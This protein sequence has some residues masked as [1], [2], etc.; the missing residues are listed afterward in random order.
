MTQARGAE[1]WRWP[2]LDE[3]DGPSA[4]FRATTFGEADSSAA[5]DPDSAE[6]IIDEGRERAE[7]LVARARDEAEQIRHDAREEAWAEAFAD[8]KARLDATLKESVAEQT[9]AFEQARTA[10][11]ERIDASLEERLDQ[12]EQQLAGLVAAMAEKVI[13][14]SVEDDAQVVVD[15]VRATIE[16]A[17]GARRFTVRVPAPDEDLVREATAE[18]LAAADG[19]ERLEI[20]PDEAIG[21][22]GCIVET[23]RGRFDARIETQIE[24]LEDEIGRELGGGEGQ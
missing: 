11:L 5:H 19:A 9:A 1:P 12:L 13:R 16:E 7:A 18:L 2:D 14:R 22:G 4:G 21:P 6:R 17:V 10:V 23:E 3:T 15:V 24:L 8:A 20:V